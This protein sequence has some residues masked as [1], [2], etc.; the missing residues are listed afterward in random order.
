MIPQLAADIAVAAVASEESAP[1]LQADG[2]DTGSKTWRQEVLQQERQQTQLNAVQDD[3]EY[4]I[5][6]PALEAF[7]SLDHPLRSKLGNRVALQLEPLQG[8]DGLTLALHRAN[9][10]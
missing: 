5:N 7:G 9:V 8:I 6:A 10:D 1:N 4:D 3:D 2:E